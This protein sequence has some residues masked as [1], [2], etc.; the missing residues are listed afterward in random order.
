MQLVADI[1]N[2][3]I[4][5]GQCGPAGI[6]Q[7]AYVAPDDP[8][9][10]RKQLQEWRADQSNSWTL[11]GSHPDRRDRFADWLRKRGDTVRVL[12]NSTEIPLA[13]LLP[14]PDRVG[15]DRLLN[16]LAAKELVPPGAPAIIVDAGSAITVDLLNDSGAFAGGAILPG[17]RMMAQALHDHTAVLP[18]VEPPA[19]APAAL[20]GDTEAAIQAGIFWSAAGGIAAL[21]NAMSLLAPS[22]DR[23]RVFVTGGDAS[24][25]ECG[26]FLD[27]SRYQV[28]FRPLLT[29]EGIRLAA[30]FDRLPEKTG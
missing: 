29:L 10:W 2:S 23:V 19:L 9:S 24:R 16:A 14:R 21:A 6:V 7:S 27:R 20:G 25:F 28:E 26:E 3:R 13:I 8:D 22:T 1:G 12:K 4:K 15:L 17:L 18:F 5:W 30:A 11:A